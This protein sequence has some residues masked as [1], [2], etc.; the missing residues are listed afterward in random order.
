MFLTYALM[1]TITISI[2][3]DLLALMEADIQAKHFANRSEYIRALLRNHFLGEVEPVLAHDRDSKYLAQAGEG[4][5]HTMED[6]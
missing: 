5:Y 1:A 2:N 4:T 3:D 6:L